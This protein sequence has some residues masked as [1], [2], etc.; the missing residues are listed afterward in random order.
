MDDEEGRLYHESFA[1]D[2]FNLANNFGSDVIEVIAVSKNFQESETLA[3]A[4]ADFIKLG[5]VIGVCLLYMMVHL[6]SLFLGL[7]SML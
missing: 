3:I 6:R 2:V 5:I 7:V 1:R 4:Q